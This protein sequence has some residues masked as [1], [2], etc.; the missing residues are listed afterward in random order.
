MRKIPLSQGKFAIVDNDDFAELNQWK[1]CATKGRRNYTFY[2]GRNVPNKGKKPPQIK[3]LMHRFIAKCPKGKIIDHID[4]D[5][6]NNRKSNLRICTQMENQLN[7]HCVPRSNTSGFV[8]IS[9]NKNAGKWMVGGMRKGKY[10]W[11]GYYLKL[12]DAKIAL[13]NL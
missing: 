3:L 11:G 5:G 9:W 7:R 10:R 6:L 4:G 2:A 12:K 8:G 13:K 1:W